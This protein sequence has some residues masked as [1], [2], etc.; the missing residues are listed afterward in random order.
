LRALPPRATGR[1]PGGRSLLAIAACAAV[2]AAVS[3]TPFAHD[4]DAFGG[5]FRSHDAGA[6]W[7][8]IN[9]GFFPSGVLA[10]AVSPR[11]SNHLLLAT[12]S[13]VW[14]SRNGGRDWA[15]EAPD[16]LNGPAFGV[17][18]DANGTHPLVAGASTLF[19]DDG[20]RW[21]PVRIPSAAAPARALLAGTVPGRVYLAG[22]SGVYRSD[23]WGRSWIEGAAS[24][25][26]DHVDALL[27]P[28]GRADDVHVI[29]AEIVWSS[30]DGAR[31][32]QQRGK[33]PAGGP[34]ETLGLDPAQPTVLW[35][36]SG[37]QVFRNGSLGETWQPV[38]KPLPEASA[39]ARAIA[40]ANEVLV[41]ATDRGVFRSGDGGERWELAKYN[42]PAH[43]SA[44][45]LVSDP[46]APA[47]LYAG[48]A[49]STYEELRARVRADESVF[50][51]AGFT[52][53]ASGAALAAVVL[54]VF[55]VM[56]YLRARKT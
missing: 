24:F 2:L 52:N 50:S 40:V 36:V 7:S 54:A 3:L 12:D 48:F 13:G 45:V 4:Q 55:A 38:G 11:D 43:L 15:I 28:P 27:V 39:K 20:D 17:V 46:H 42:L 44:A 49:L 32:W 5:L 16:V 1:I 23:D 33:S 21:R 30:N 31:N 26:A 18:F 29:A 35:A 53:L 19:R 6:T 56:R 37:A 51:G 41:V 8:P 25:K 47:N 10:V 14:R 9:P 22:K 34:F